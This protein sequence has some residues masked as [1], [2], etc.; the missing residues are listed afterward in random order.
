MRTTAWG[1]AALL[2]SS[3]AIAA[4]AEPAR[5]ASAPAFRAQ[6]LAALPRDG[7]LTNGGNLG[8]QRYSPLTQINR[9]NVAGLKAVWRASLRGSGTEQKHS[10]QAQTLMHEGTLYTV[11]G[12]N[13]VFAISMETGAVLWEYKANLQAANV[14]PC[15]GW[16]S[17][18]VGLGDGKV[19]VGQL[20]NKVVALD[21]RTGKVVWSVQSETLRDA[22]FTITSAPLYYE[23]LVIVG[24]AGGEL[25][26]RGRLKAFDAKTGKLR[27]VFYTIP[28]PG[29]LGHDTWPADNDA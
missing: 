3:G 19:F 10:G 14:V 8:N 23:G 13:D 1:I 21:Q 24:H 22:G 26:I 16:V 5:I 4:S 15:C 11:T 17:R 20:D 27:W 12:A 28:G 18:G 2:A 29:E 25:A 9:G 7:W 6:Q